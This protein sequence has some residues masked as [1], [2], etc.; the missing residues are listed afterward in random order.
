MLKYLRY[1]GKPI[2]GLITD[3]IAWHKD[4]ISDALYLFFIR[5]I[6]IM[7]N[8]MAPRPVIESIYVVICENGRRT[9]I[10]CTRIEFRNLTI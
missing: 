3:I 1:R 5:R 4:M 8:F 7:N 10:L 9:W 2:H 6:V